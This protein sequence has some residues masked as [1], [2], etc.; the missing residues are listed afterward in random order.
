MNKILNL[1]VSNFLVLTF[2]LKKKFIKKKSSIIEVIIFSYNRVLQLDSLLKSLEYFFDRKIQINVIF[3][4][5]KN[6]KNSY[7]KLIYKYEKNKN[8]I[9]FEQVY[10]FKKSLNLLLKKIQS[11]NKHNKEILFFVDDQIIFQRIDSKMLEGM[12]SIAPIATFR[13]GLNT[14]YSYNLDKEQSHKGYSYSLKDD[15]LSWK[16]KFK[17]DDFSYIFSFDASTIPFELFYGFS[18]YLSYRGPNSLESYMN[19][20]GLTYKLL[21]LGVCSMKIQKVINIVISKVQNET[22]NRGVFIENE[23]LNLLFEK[24]WSLSLDNNKIKK[25]NSPHTNNGYYIKKKGKIKFLN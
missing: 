16:P 21:N 1:F 11:E 2:F 23:K 15:F 13:L 20:G 19:Y 24:D 22:E 6:F 7:K 8:I 18:K 12:L 3:K 10:H 25:F 17:R 9:F 4:S 5:D 14:T